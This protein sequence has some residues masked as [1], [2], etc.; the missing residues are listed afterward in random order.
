[1]NFIHFIEINLPCERCREE[2]AANLMFETIHDCE[3]VNELRRKVSESKNYGLKLSEIYEASL[4]R[5][6]FGC[7]RK[8]LIVEI[9]L[10]YKELVELVKE[11]YVSVALRGETNVLSIQEMQ[12][13][14]NKRV[15]L[16]K[17]NPLMCSAP[18]YGIDIVWHKQKLYE[19]ENTSSP[20]IN[21]YLRDALQ[22][23]LR[24]NG[25]DNLFI[26][27]LRI[28]LNQTSKIIVE[29]SVGNKI[30]ETAA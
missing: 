28:Y 15:E 13:Y 26:N 2:Y 17:Q 22:K 23:G 9:E 21:S 4:T 12:E 14:K 16:L 10:A 27:G 5:Y 6:C 11:E 30:A 25:W 8:L 7:R 24:E 20:K 1:M 19:K 3:N 18:F 29:D